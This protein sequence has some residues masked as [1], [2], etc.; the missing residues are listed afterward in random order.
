MLKNITLG[1]Y[2]PGDSFI[3]RLDPRTKLIFVFVMVV[4]IFLFK[5]WYGYALMFA[6]LAVA[7]AASGVKVKY[8]LK[9]LKPLWFIIAF[10]FVLNLLFTS[11]GTVLFEIG[12][13]KLTTD[14]LILAGELVARLVFLIMMTTLLTYTTSP[15]Q[16]TDA[17]ERLFK[18]LNK[19]G[20]PV[21]ELAMMMTIAIRFIPTLIEE[22]DKI[23][24][25]QMARGAE[26]DSKNLFKRTAGMVP[27][28]V[29]LFVS[30][31]RRA[32]ELA[33]AMEARCYNGGE[34]RTKMKVLVMTARDYVVFALLL[35]MIASPVLEGIWLV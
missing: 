24:K 14:G 9:G 20:F 28:L 26:F 15:I 19:I 7:V 4:L 6:G 35:I 8:L 17:I 16:L 5:T 22:T 1:Q 33:F 11:T 23:M 30:A 31:F 29:P 12:R 25:A 27:L 10:T 2:Y 32:D 34:G 13:F 3:H 18:P 21:H